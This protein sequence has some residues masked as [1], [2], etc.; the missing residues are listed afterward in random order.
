VDAA[1][2]AA[3]AQRKP[4]A[5]P[6]THYITTKRAAQLARSEARRLRRAKRN[7]GDTEAPPTGRC[8]KELASSNIL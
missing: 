2:G 3:A 7:M 5:E 8:L 1:A 6:N 4:Q